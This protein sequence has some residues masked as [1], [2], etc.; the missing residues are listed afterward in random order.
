MGMSVGKE[1][2]DDDEFGGVNSEINTTPLV[3][4]MLVL[5]II[6]LITVPVVVSA[7]PVKLPEEENLAVQTKPQNVNLVV[8]TSCKTYWG[9]VEVTEE[10]L[11]ERLAKTIAD[12]I[13][14]DATNIPE[15]HIRGDA[16]TEYNCVGKV[17]QA[18]QKAGYPKIGFLTKKPPNG[19]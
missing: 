1:G 16:E 6:F 14:K 18:V 12:A 2:G 19:Y 11:A 10:E 3:D 7:K 4:V 15:V 5:L 9:A 13:A 8:D 17:V